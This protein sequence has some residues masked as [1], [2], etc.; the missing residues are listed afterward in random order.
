MKDHLNVIV[1]EDEAVIAQLLEFHVIQAG[2]NVLD[3]AHNSERALDLVHNLQPD[4]VL[5]DINI[6]G[7]R[8][9]I[10][11]GK[12][13]K[14]KYKIPIIF[15]TAL[16][17][18]DTLKRAAEVQPVSYLVKPYKK[19]DLLAAMAIGMFNY[20]NRQQE[21]SVTI[22]LINGAALSPLSEKEYEVLLD[23]SQG[24]TNDQIAT[25]QFLS[26]NTI[27]WH[28]GN[29]YSKLGVKNRTEAARFISDLLK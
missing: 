27:K 24:L 16:S 11:V 4:L 9:G 13:I 21:R 7:E 29:I 26:L 10:Q 17:D 8:D 5:L 19:D 12:I 15:I 6:L 25:K 28:S 20:Q 22:E 18:M 14:D 1:V 23:I 2:H 3:I